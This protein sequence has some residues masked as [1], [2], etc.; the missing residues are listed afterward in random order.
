M[1]RWLEEFYAIRRN[2]KEQSRVCLAC[3]VFRIE[4][5]NARRENE[6]LLNHV[7]NPPKSEEI[8]GFTH[9]P[10]PPLLKHKPWKVKQQELETQDRQE[11]QRILSEFKNKISTPLTEKLEKDMGIG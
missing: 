3:E 9:D 11:H 4:L 5:A 6:K 2:H 7:L 8:M 1:W 10:V